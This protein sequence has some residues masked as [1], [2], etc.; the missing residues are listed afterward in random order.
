[1]ID[2]SRL[3][4]VELAVAAISASEKT[5]TGGYSTNFHEF[6]ERIKHVGLGTASILEPLGI[7]GVTYYGH[8]LYSDDS[9]VKLLQEIHI[10]LFP[11][12]PFDHDAYRVSRNLPL[13][14]L[15][16]RWRNALCDDLALW[17]HIYYGRD[18][19]PT[20]DANFYK[21]SKKPL[22]VVLGAKE[23][24]RPEELARSMA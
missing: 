9:A 3:G 10:I 19:F 4:Q 5:L 11:G 21:Q 15:D 6:E 2:R 7:Y 24:L 8:S 13:G 20:S 1:L 22:L 18:I 17:C 23:I 16:P 12:I 14:D